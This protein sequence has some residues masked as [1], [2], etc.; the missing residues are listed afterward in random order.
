M[1]N[2]VLCKKID[3]KIEEIANSVWMNFLLQ[4]IHASVVGCPSELWNNYF[5]N[6]PKLYF[7]D[8]VNW[9]HLNLLQL[10]PF[11]I[12]S[13]ILDYSLALDCME[14]ITEWNNIYYF[15]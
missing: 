15:G 1:L 10:S 6:I 13:S 14:K 4:S 12:L 9:P 11:E 7:S 2:K 3:K 5:P 8:P